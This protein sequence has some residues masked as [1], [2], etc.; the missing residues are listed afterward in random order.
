MSQPK[1]SICIPS[2]NHARFLPAAIE[3]ALGQTYKNIE[4]IIVDDG[5]TDGSLQIAESYAARYPALIQVFT[6]P[7]QRNLGIAAT[8]NLAFQKATGKYWS[9]L[10][11]D[12]VYYPHKIATQVAVLEQDPELG[13]VYG[14]AHYI[15]EQGRRQPELGLFGIDITQAPDPVERLIQSNAISAMTTLAR[16][17]CME[18]IGRE[19]ETLVYSDW[20]LWVR[21]LAH[22]PVK[23]LPRVCVCYRTHSYNS[24]IGISD[25]LRFGHSLQV[26]LKLRRHATQIGGTLARP[27]TQ[28]LLDLQTAYLYHC[29]R[30]DIEARQH[31]AAAFTTDPTLR[32]DVSYLSRW[33]QSCVR[34]L[35]LPEPALADAFRAWV[36]AHLPAAVDEETR[37]ALARAS[38]LTEAGQRANRYGRLAMAWQSRRQLLAALL[39]DPDAKR[40]AELFV[41]YAELL[42]GG[43]VNKQL[44]RLSQ[45]WHAAVS[46]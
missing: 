9:G 35:P 20:D 32:T 14:Y 17:A 43:R 23:F 21:M 44:R 3:S 40:D 5:S 6:H 41:A 4:I 18:Q 24:S 19:D 25:E 46:R 29:M 13:W 34:L 7:G 42:V 12:D 39:R 11:S 28:A 1:V 10:P 33:L 36:L 2:Y 16:R 37:Q 22:H 27:R 30:A 8:A 38:T 15:D 31:L 26:L 45:W